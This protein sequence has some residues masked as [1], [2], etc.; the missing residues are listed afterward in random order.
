MPTASYQR[1]SP[2]GVIQCRPSKYSAQNAK[3]TYSAMRSLRSFRSIAPSCASLALIA[4]RAAETRSGRLLC[5]GMGMSRKR[6][7]RL[8]V[9]LGLGDA[10]LCDGE[11]LWV[12]LD[13]DEVAARLDAGNASGAGTHEGVEDGGT[14]RS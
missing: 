5:A 11:V 8:I 2:P 1:C 3:Y 4:R 13:A 14:G 10:A 7:L 12:N 9:A 6:E